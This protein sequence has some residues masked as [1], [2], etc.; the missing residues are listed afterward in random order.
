MSDEHSSVD[1]TLIQAWALM[2]SF[3]PK[4]G[5]GELLDPG[6]NGERDFRGET[7][8]NDT[9][10][11]TTDTTPGSIANARARRASSVSWAML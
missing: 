1:G 3:R 5:L 8:S 11:S 10:G 9:H 6:R 2:K 4:V 7:R